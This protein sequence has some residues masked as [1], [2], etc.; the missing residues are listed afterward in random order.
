MQHSFR[1]EQLKENCKLRGTDNVRGQISEYI[2]APNGGYCVSYPSNMFFAT[3]TVLKIGE[4][5]SN[6]PQF[7]VR[8]MMWISQVKIFDGP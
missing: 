1:R 5:Y 3:S 4:H 2:F 8:H 6:I 7:S